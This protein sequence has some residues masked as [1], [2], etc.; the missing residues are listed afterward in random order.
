[1]LALP[2]V[3][4]RAVEFGVP[5]TWI[6]F[7]SRGR[8]LAICWYVWY[9]EASCLFLYAA[10][11]IPS[12][13]TT[14]ALTLKFILDNKVRFGG[15]GGVIASVWMVCVQ[16]KGHRTINHIWHF[17]STNSWFCFLAVVHVSIVV[18]FTA[19]ERRSESSIS[20]NMHAVKFNT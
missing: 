2:Y 8:I 20:T 19:I 10:C 7:T 13:T 3:I 5:V 4:H 11:A 15:G 1:M 17:F 12:L 14:S 16:M 18:L 6:I 9:T